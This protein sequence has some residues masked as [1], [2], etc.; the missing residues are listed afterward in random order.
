MIRIQ[1]ISKRRV[2]WRYYDDNYILY[3][4]TGADISVEEMMEHYPNNNNNNKKH[5]IIGNGIVKI[6]KTLGWTEKGKKKV[7]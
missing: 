5:P 4:T 3:L 7:K 2:F 6:K 1:R